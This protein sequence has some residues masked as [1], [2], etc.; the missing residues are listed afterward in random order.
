MPFGRQLPGG[1]PL[2]FETFPHLLVFA[3]FIGLALFT[4]LFFGTVFLS[5]HPMAMET[6]TLEEGSMDVDHVTKLPGL[7]NDDSVETV[8]LPGE[9]LQNGLFSIRDVNM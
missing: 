7:A 5:K 3:L 1:L 6:D 9:F 4:W 8:Q 2:L